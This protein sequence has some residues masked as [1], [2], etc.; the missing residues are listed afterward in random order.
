MCEHTERTSAPATLSAVPFSL[1]NHPSFKPRIN[2]SS[3]S[4]IFYPPAG[5]LRLLSIEEK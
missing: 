1:L 3:R 4:L 5:E 2:V